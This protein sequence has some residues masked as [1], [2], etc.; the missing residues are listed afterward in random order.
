MALSLA[1]VA[2]AKRACVWSELFLQVLRFQSFLSIVGFCMQSSLKGLF[3][4][5]GKVPGFPNCPRGL[6][7]VIGH[8]G[9]FGLIPER[10]YVQ[11][12]KTHGQP[13][14]KPFCASRQQ[15]LL[16]HGKKCRK[17]ESKI[18]RLHEML[19]HMLRN[20]KRMHE[21]QKKVQPTQK[22]LKTLKHTIFHEF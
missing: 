20:R 15:K 4:L 18:C 21:S 17:N 16:L 22:T 8:K 6:P 11:V 5:F 7:S 1:T 3:V 2:T 19:Q 14:Q 9:S 13:C 12:R 10:S